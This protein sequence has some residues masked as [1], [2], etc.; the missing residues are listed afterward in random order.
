MRIER[1]EDHVIHGAV[2]LG[3]AGLSFALAAGGIGLATTLEP[4]SDALAPL[5]IGGFSFIAIGTSAA[6][7]GF[8]V[9]LT[10]MDPTYYRLVPR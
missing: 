10:P 7:Y 5:V 4:E 9:V 2:A 8:I 1:V 6:I 3:I